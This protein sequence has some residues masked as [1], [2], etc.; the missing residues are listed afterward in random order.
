MHL[1]GLDF[2][3]YLPDPG[4]PVLVTL[5]LPP[6][7][8]GSS[9]LRVDRPATFLHGLSVGEASLFPDDASL[10]PAI[11]A[12]I[13]LD[14]FRFGARKHRFALSIGR[15]C[16]EKGHHLALS[17]AARAGVPLLIAGRVSPFAVHE[18]YFREAIAPRLDRDRRFLGPI[19]GVRKRR[20]LA[21]ARCVI[22]PSA[23]PETRSL[24]AMEAL[25]SG[26]PVV[27]FR[28][29]ALPDIV[30]HGVTG[31]LVDD[32]EEMADAI[33]AAE[34]LDPLACRRAAE[35]RFSAE[36]MTHAFF[37]A[38][39]GIV[40]ASRCASQIARDIDSRGRPADV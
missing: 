23:M 30:E 36:R 37:D 29:G 3:G 31:F 11:P 2:D 17:A 39:A 10:L 27:A 20:L 9:V 13:A 21:G 35:E 5:H 7:L 18:R 33:L 14:R 15:V 25:A 6:V 12:G 16:P 1:L 4:P 38:Y 8:Y 28:R 19:A 22:V 26:T 40:G 24:V 32:V 34:T